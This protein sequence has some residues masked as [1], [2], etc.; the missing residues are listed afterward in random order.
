ME[1]VKDEGPRAKW[2]WLKAGLSVV[3]CY[4][5]FA[6]I[7]APNTQTYLGFRAQKVIEPYVN[8]FELVA[9]WNF[10][11]PDPGPPPVYLEYE[12]LDASGETVERGRW[13][14]MKDPYFFRERQNRRIAAARFMIGT[15]LR[16]EKMMVPYLCKEHPQ[17]HSVRLWKTQYTIPGLNEV[18]S[19]ARAIG[20]DVGVG[21]QSISHSF[22]DSKG[23]GA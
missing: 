21:H 4:H 12:L 9:S 19:G 7:L 20:D 6:V 10:F 18:E 3:L 15:D 2:K 11:A 17:T 14:D 13:P 23:K 22:C 16:A 1:S 8:F 5:L